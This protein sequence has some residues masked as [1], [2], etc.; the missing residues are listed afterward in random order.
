MKPIGSVMSFSGGAEDTPSVR[1][2]RYDCPG[3]LHHG[4]PTLN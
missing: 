4:D 2:Q 1:V 3:S